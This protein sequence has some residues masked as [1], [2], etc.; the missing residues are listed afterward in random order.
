M[1][2]RPKSFTLRALHAE[3]VRFALLCV[4]VLA[5]PV[6]HPLAEARAAQNGLSDV[7]CTQFG[8]VPARGDEIPI[9]AADDCPC[10]ILCGAMATGQMLKAL[11]AGSSEPLSAGVPGLQWPGAETTDA[12]QPN[13]L[14]G[15]R[16]IRGPP[17][18]I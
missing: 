16:G 18:S 12:I 2:R 11:A 14:S 4:M 5:L 10:V 7:I 8:F 1:I 17:Y 13:L 15:N 3:A 6:L 9:G